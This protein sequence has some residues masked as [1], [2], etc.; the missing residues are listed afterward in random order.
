MAPAE[1][2]ALIKE[3]AEQRRQLKGEVK[4]LAK[5]RADYIAREVEAAGGA[6]D[7]LDE[8]LYKAVKSQAAKSGISYEAAGSATY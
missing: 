4:K 1:Q 5:Q 2:K 6:S 8:K 7:S 3:K